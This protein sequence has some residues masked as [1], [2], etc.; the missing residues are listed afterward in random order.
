MG[1]EFNRRL[2]ALRVEEAERIAAGVY[3]SDPENEYTEHEK[4][5][6]EF[7]DEITDTV[8]VNRIAARL[9]NG[10][11][12]RPIT[13]ASRSRT[14]ERPTDDFINEMESYG[15]DMEGRGVSSG[16]NFVNK[17]KRM[18]SSGTIGPDG[19]HRDGS[20]APSKRMRVE[21]AAR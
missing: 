14:K 10:K 11:G 3:D 17:K 19:E 16:S 2:E 6:I 4:K 9:D 7:A 5:M 8:K 15:I 21:H 13:R 12:V 18:R 1:E 20:R